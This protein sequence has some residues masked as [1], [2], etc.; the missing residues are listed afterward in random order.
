MAF[1]TFVIEITIGRLHEHLI[2]TLLNRPRIAGQ[3]RRKI[4]VT[5]LLVAASAVLQLFVLAVVASSL[6]EQAE[7][8]GSQP[9]CNKDVV[10]VLFAPFKVLGSGR[11]FAEVFLAAM[12]FV[13]AARR[14]WNVVHKPPG[15]PLPVGTCYGT[16][17]C[18]G[19]RPLWLSKTLALLVIVSLFI[20]N[21]ELLRVENNVHSGINDWDFGQ[22]LP[23]LLLVFPIT[24]IYKSVP[25]QTIYAMLGIQTGRPSTTISYNMHPPEATPEAASEPVDAIPMTAIESNDG[26]SQMR[27]AE[28]LAVTPSMPTP[29]THAVQASS[30]RWRSG[31]AKFTHRFTQTP[32][33][34]CRNGGRVSPSE[35]KFNRL[36]GLPRRVKKA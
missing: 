4:D 17:R 3:S 19:F 10:L 21:I 2:D 32:V 27:P 28:E 18:P 35:G 1:S 8:F 5:H 29:P 34:I 24:T 11:V 13:A 15:L 23:M 9:E 12:I 20:V 14:L 22:I 31:R 33:R 6:F 36:N 7:T 25:V 26:P 30:T 16:R